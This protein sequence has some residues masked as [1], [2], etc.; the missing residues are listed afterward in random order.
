MGR[1]AGI[2]LVVVILSLA[3]EV[4]SRA[5]TPGSVPDACSLLAPADLHR[6]FGGT[7]GSGDLTASPSGDETIC[8]WIVTT[9]AKGNGFSAQLDVKSPFTARDFAEQRRI[10]Q[11]RT[12]TIEHVGRRAFGERVKQAGVVYDDLWVQRGTIGFRL[13][14][15][16]DLGS[17]PLR[18]LARVVVGRLC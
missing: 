15:L 14:V 1:I 17:K 5:A 8:Q 2:C 16:E 11:G 9:S 4:A 7:V 13:E 10:A 18:R 6:V 12:T 3:T